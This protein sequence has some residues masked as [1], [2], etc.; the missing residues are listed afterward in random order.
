MS[1]KKALLLSLILLSILSCAPKELSLLDAYLVLQK[2]GLA[3]KKLKGKVFV[4][5]AFILLNS[6]DQSGGSYGTFYLDPSSLII[7]LRPPL[8]TEIILYWDGN[9][10]HFF[11]ID[12]AKK[13]VY[14]LH[15]KE[16]SLED[17]PSYFLGLKEGKVKFKRNN[18]M[19]EYTFSKEELKGVLQ[20]NLFNLSWKIKEIT[21]TEE[22]PPPLS[23]ENYKLK[24]IEVDL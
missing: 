8:S 12:T 23:F 10:K 19:G 18:L 14:R 5:G 4:E 7:F 9:P 17:L 22:Y 15:F 24:T 20:A 21:F 3:E 13:R 6:Q 1:L 16:F 2:E 11:L